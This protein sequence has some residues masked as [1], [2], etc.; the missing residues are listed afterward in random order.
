MLETLETSADLSGFTSPSSHFQSFDVRRFFER[1]RNCV[2]CEH[3]QI[4][5]QNDALRLAE[6]P[7]SIGCSACST[8]VSSSPRRV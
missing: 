3:S 6:P 2:G 4:I 5:D 8:D 1:L 7:S